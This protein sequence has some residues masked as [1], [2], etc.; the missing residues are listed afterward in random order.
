MTKVFAIHE[1]ELLPGVDP[2]EFERLAVQAGGWDLPGMRSYILKGDRGTRRGQFAMMYEFDSEQRRAELFP[3]EGGPGAEVIAYM[4]T[5]GFRRRFGFMD[6]LAAGGG[7][8]GY[9]YSDYVVLA[10]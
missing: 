9:V 10:Q 1:I 2:A 5:E 8:P 6:T 4:A 3:V 7:S